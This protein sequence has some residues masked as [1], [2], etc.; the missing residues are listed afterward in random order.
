MSLN[1]YKAI[2]L[3]LLA[4]IMCI[5]ETASNI[6]LRFHSTEVFTISIVLPVTLIVMMRWGPWGLIHAGLGGVIYAILNSGSGVVMLIYAA[7]N[8]GIGLCLVWIKAFGGERIR[9]SVPLM[10][11]YSVTG[12]VGMC[13]GRGL[14]AWVLGEAVLWAAVVRYLS[15]ES[16]S[17]VIGTIVV[18]IAS[19]QNGVFENQLTYLRRIADEEE[20][21][22]GK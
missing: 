6:A 4:A 8:F 14:L 2:D 11:L 20:S 3:T 22:N 17:M 21:K 7:G 10:I 19:C 18:Y 12:Y 5:L 15:V 9:K 1:R 16:L 13:I